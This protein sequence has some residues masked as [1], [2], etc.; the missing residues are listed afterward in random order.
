MNGIEAF[1]LVLGGLV[2]F[3]I[4]VV[5]CVGSSAA[6]DVMGLSNDISGGYCIMS[7]PNGC[8]GCTGCDGCGC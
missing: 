4:L 7:C 5:V 3:F 6:N 1:F 8:T 2:I